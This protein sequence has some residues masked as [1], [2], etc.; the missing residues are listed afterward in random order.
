MVPVR[1]TV[2]ADW[3][4]LRDIRLEAPSNRAPPEPNSARTPSSRT[5]RRPVNRPSASAAA[6]TRTKASEDG[7]A[8]VTPCV[9]VTKGAYRTFTT[10]RTA[11]RGSEERSPAS[12]PARR[13][14]S[15]WTRDQSAMFRWNVSSR[16]CPRA[17]YGESSTSASPRPQASSTSHG[18]VIGPNSA[19]SAS[20]S[21]AA[22]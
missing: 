7:T 1:E 5:G 21:A 19:A 4:A 18:P 12:S 2:M 3:Q 22:S 11:G 6:R 16:P 17:T 15:A 13:A 9:S 20:G 8:S 14:T 10:T